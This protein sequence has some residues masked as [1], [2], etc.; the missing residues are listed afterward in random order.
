M[1]TRTQHQLRRLF[2]KSPFSRTQGLKLLSATKGR[3][4]IS[5]KV[6]PRHSQGLGKVHGGVVT[7]LAD[8][9]ATFAGYTVVEA[10]EHL[11]T[12]NLSMAF[13]AGAVEGEGMVATA[14]VLHAG[15]TTVVARVV[16]CRE[17]RPVMASGTFTMIR[18]GESGKLSPSGG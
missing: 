18:M 6:A 15:R 13:M 5:M 8:T 16:V 4:R 12:T 9:A 1:P 3:A 2:R 17:R 7:A 14:E 10:G 11:L